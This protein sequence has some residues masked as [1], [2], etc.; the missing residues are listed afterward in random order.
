[1][2]DIDVSP[3]YFFKY[4]W[5]TIVLLWGHW[6]PY[7]GFLVMSPLG[8]KARVGSALFACYMYVIC[9]LRYTSGATHLLAASSAAGHFP[10][11][12]SRGGTWIGFERVIARTEGERATIVP[13]TR[14]CDID[15]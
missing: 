1:M 7:F 2:R 13:A 11:C 4:F 10:K 5:R 14:L 8:F 3:S 6:H 9:S 15:V 12:I